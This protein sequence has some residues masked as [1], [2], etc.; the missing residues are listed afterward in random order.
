M[1]GTFYSS[2]LT[3]NCFANGNNISMTP[4]GISTTSTPSTYSMSYLQLINNPIEFQISNNW[5]Y[6]KG[7]SSISKIKI[8]L[9][10][11]GNN[12]P[13]SVVSGD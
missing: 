5:T 12:S 3:V 7:L 11:V 10:Q 4:I 9:Y 1:I 2:I 6:L 8:L 13:I